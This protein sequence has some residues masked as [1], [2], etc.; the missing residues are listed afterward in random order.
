MDLCF[1]AALPLTRRAVGTVLSTSLRSTT[2]GRALYPPILPAPARKP[3]V[4]AVRCTVAPVSSSSTDQKDSQTIRS[5]ERR[6]K[7]RKVHEDGESM[8]GKEICVKGWVRTLRDQ[9][10]FAFID[11]NDGSSV[12]GLQIV[13]EDGVNLE[14]VESLKTGCAVS[15]KGEVAR[16]LGK[17]QAFELKATEV[18]LIGQATDDYPLQKKR[19]NM[20]F[21]RTIAH[22]RPRT[23]VIG[24]MSRVRS[25]L[26]LATHEFF[27]THGFIYLNSP[28]ITA[29]DCEGAGEMFRVTTVIPRNG[30]KDDIPV[31]KNMDGSIDF[32][33]DFFGKPAF[34]TVSGQLSAETYACGLGDVYTFGPT[35]RA[36][37]SNTSR[38]LAEFWMIEPEMAFADLKDDMDN[39]EA[40][41]KFVVNAALSR[42]NA[43]LSFFNRFVQ[44]NLLE[45]LK[46]VVNEPFVRLSY[47]EAIDI[48]EGSNK[49]AKTGQKRFEFEVAWGTDLQSEHERYLAEE[50]FKRPVFVYN[51]PASIKAFY[52]KANEEDTG[53]TVRAMDLLV[54]GIGELIGGSAREDRLDV[55]KEKIQ[56]MG[57]SPEDYWWYL[58]LRRYGSVPHA[59]YGLGFERLVQFVTGVENIRDVIPFPRYPGNAEF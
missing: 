11:L 55:L 30:K 10:R 36:E 31:N 50:H 13:V 9:K 43:D 25:I 45:K 29:S 18:E 41:V 26:A 20:E 24:A 14:V 32:E 37:N 46:T 5:R 33:Q 21:L 56:S 15:V 54:P 44:K 49:T 35:F 3:G 4:A 58:D 39:A 42:C 19:H 6:V 1:G 47:T 38:H 51:Y 27:G 16:S 59:G 7:V 17:G 28:I 12:T 52:M 57:L 2:F 8:L 40:F 22:L 48:L 34:L 53:K 23:N